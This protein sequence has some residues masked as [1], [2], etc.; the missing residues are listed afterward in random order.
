VSLLHLVLSVPFSMVMA[1][2]VAPSQLLSSVKLAFSV[3]A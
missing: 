3:M 2:F 1:L